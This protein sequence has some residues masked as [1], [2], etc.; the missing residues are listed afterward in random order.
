MTA[1][2]DHTLLA[3]NAVK[4]GIPH[5]LS[6]VMVATHRATTSVSRLRRRSHSGTPKNEGPANLPTAMHETEV[7][8]V[9]FQ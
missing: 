7:P 2:T 9:I 1:S 8:V 4:P 3:K 5:S 6:C